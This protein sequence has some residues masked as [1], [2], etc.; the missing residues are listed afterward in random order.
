MDGWMDKIK[1]ANALHG[2]NVFHLIQLGTF[3]PEVHF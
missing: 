3:S 2:F 1:S